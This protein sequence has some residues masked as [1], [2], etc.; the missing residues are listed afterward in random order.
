MI[1][2]LVADD[3][4]VVRD[5]LMAILSTQPDFEIAG[6]ANTGTDAVH[7]AVTLQPDILLLDLAMPELDGV[8][9]LLQLKNYQLATKAIIFTAFDTDER[10][11]SAIQAGASGYLLKGAPRDELFHAIRVVSDG[12]SLLAPMIASKV[13]KQIRQPSTNLS[14]T[15][16]EDD[17]LRLVARGLPNK[18][19]A[20]ELSISE[21]TVKFHITSLM[22]KMGVN[23]RT[24]LVSRAVQRGILQLPS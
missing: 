21:R 20:R 5:G 11:V 18:I 4:P 14:V 15:A 22:Q 17:V 16:R 8:G 10:I 13:M 24:E 1:R 3:H 9:V 2:I 23:N 6:E 19:I 7:K 12:G